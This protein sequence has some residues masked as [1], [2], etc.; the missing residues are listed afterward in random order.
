[1]A[2]PLRSRYNHAPIYLSIV[3]ELVLQDN[4]SQIST[5][6]EFLLQ[7]G[8]EY[9]IFDMGRGIRKIPAQTFLDIEN[10]LKAPAYPRNGHAWYGLVF[11]NKTM[12]EQHYIWFVK[13]PLDEQGLLIPATRNHFLQ[14]IV[15]A[16]GQQLENA[17]QKN[18]QLP[19][20]PYSFIPNQHQLAD[21]NAISRAHLSLPP[22]S[23]YEQVTSHI[24]SPHSSHWQTIAIQGIAD[25]AA[26]LEKDN[27]AQLLSEQFEALDDQVKYPLLISLEHHETDIKVAETIQAWLTRH[28][29]NALHWQ[30]GLRGLS[31]SKSTGLVKSLVETCLNS[32]DLCADA[33]L[34]MIIAGRQW[35]HLTDQSLLMRFLERVAQADA[36]P[37]SQTEGQLFAGVYTDLVQIPAL[38]SNVL[39]VLRQPDKPDAVTQAIGKLFSGQAS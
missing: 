37:Q 27:H 11:W 34:L 9:R 28:P 23:H 36:D 32:D 18:G 38:R 35:Q 7:A 4:M 31:Q 8:T 15:D 2:F 20:N 1:M 30:H 5:I 29:Q 26:R 39:G 10:A 13:L 3:R 22:S 21:F 17:E 16:L 12:S 19:E 33:G 25:F 6:S 24:A 14:I